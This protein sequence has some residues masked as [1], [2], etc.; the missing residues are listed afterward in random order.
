MGGKPIDRDN[1]MSPAAQVHGR[2]AFNPEDQSESV[3]SQRQGSEGRRP[4]RSHNPNPKGRR[5]GSRNPNAMKAM[6]SNP[7]VGPEQPRKVSKGKAA[8]D[9]NPEGSGEQAQAYAKPALKPGRA[10]WARVWLRRKNA[11]KQRPSAGSTKI[12]KP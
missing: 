2:H 11:E 10:A 9:Q 8:K 5:R 6:Q 3:A 12:V 4:K 1:V 7:A